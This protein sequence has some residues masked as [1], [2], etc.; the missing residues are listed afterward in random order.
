MKL[1]SHVIDQCTGAS[2][3]VVRFIGDV[4]IART[5]DGKMF[6]VKARRIG[7]KPAWKPS[8]SYNGGPV[9]P[10]LVALAERVKRARVA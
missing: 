10:E 3:Y 8:D 7:R 2:G 9:N 5:A 4:P 6:R 1:G